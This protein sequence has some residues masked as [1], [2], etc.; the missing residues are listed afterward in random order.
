VSGKA[1]KGERERKF[2]ICAGKAEKEA[3]MLFKKRE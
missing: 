3:T 2:S 1:R